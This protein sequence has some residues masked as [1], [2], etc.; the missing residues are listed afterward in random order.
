MNNFSK[1]PVIAIVISI[2]ILLIGCSATSKLN[3]GTPA[4]YTKLQ[5]LDDSSYILLEN[6]RGKMV[7]LLFWESTCSAS[8]SM[9]S[10]LNEH[11]RK[12]HNRSDLAFIAVSSDTNEE[13]L[14]NL[15]HVR[16]YNAV[17]HAYSGNG[18][19]DEAFL[20]FRVD[21]VPQGFIIDRNGV[22]VD[23]GNPDWELIK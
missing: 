14:R 22:I 19:Y 17:T 16:N 2:S 13:D 8:K 11:A 3:P 5:R 23:S 15:I 7:G 10:S 21:S 18:G 1:L 6:L 12:L 20:A 4:P 9:L